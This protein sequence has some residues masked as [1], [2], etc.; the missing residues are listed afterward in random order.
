VSNAPHVLKTVYIDDPMHIIAPIKGKEVGM[1]SQK[2]S[3]K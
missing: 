2:Q 3:K 1:Q